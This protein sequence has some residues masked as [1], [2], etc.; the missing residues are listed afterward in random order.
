MECGRKESR[1]S[2][3]KINFKLNLLYTTPFFLYLS[4]SKQAIKLLHTTN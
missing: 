1:V 4:Q 2:L 3:K